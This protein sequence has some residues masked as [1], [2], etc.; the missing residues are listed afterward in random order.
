MSKIHQKLNHLLL[1]L[2]FDGLMVNLIK[3]LPDEREYTLSK[4]YFLHS[5]AQ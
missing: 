5:Q 1:N 2:E 4:F 3:N